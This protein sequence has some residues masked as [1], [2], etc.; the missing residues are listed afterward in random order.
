MADEAPTALEQIEVTA[1]RAPAPIEQVPSFI[2]IVSGNELRARGVRDLS[3]AVA[4]AAGVE[5]PAGGDTGPAGA[6]P[7]FWGLHEFDAFLLVVD[8][9]PWGGAFNP[10]IP[11]V[12]LN[13]VQRIEIVR[14]SA[15]V[16]Y[17]A[18]SFVG[19]IQVIHY[20][21]GTAADDAQIGYG[22]YGSVRASAS[23][24]LDPI[25]DYRQS[26]AV[27]VE[28]LAFKNAAQEIK[29]GH[30]AYRASKPLG[31]GLLRVD[32]DVAAGRQL[33]S[34]P[35]I[36]QGAVLTTL[37]PLDANS[38]PSD[39][40]ID[41][42]RY[43]LTLGFAEPGRWGQWETTIS[44]AYSDITDIRG[45]LRPTLIDD[46]SQNADS[47][48]QHRTIADDYFDTHWTVEFA[49]RLQFVYGADLLFGLGKQSSVNGAY[50]APLI[51]TG[52]LPST[53]GLHV[54]EIN[55]LSDRR[56]FGG[57]YLQVNWKPYDRWDI[58]GGVRMNQTREH[59]VSQH[60]DGF[61]AGNNLAADNT[62]SNNKLT[63]TVGASYRAWQQGAD[64]AVV[65]ASYRNAF[66]PAAID[67][68]PDYT[69][70]ILLPE[71]AQSWEAG[72]RGAL[73][74]G[75]LDYEAGLFLLDFK[76]LVVA[77]TDSLGNPVRQNAG[78]ERLKGAEFEARYRLSRDLSA[79][80]SAS[81]HDARFTDYTA[82]EGGIN[83]VANGNTLPMSP[84][85]LAGLGVMYMPAQG[86]N[87]SAVA[88]YVG[89]RYLDIAN[90][91]ATP[92]YTTLNLNIGYRW[93]RY[94]VS[95]EATNLTDRRPPVSAS[96]FGDQSYYLLPSRIVFLNFGAIL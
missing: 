91:A 53:V 92:A 87:A 74:G 2:T 76:N 72:M 20:P 84:H 79:A 70:D 4:L 66:K 46:G 45:F 42:N 50:Y 6:V 21:A 18:T 1:T 31:D 51:P 93:P 8:G 11:T 27:D 49:D 28:D 26:I 14:G 9:V 19:V 48:H 30:V 54:D 57:E 5:A 59:L 36:R 89:A 86:F 94:H 17:G 71:T 22:S 73:L 81:Y 29:N 69:P 13:N 67:F 80:V 88:N 44:F 75:R 16:M 61:D 65:F 62:G 83:V 33:P 32:A 90:M 77:T 7:S 3:G 78:G 34:S 96:E 41:E 23:K 10:A 39:A 47:Q 60:V 38:N 52:P 24:A 40:R 12:D 35:V 55:T 37:T 85:V 43:H 63:E 64:E 15:P 68:G 25:G 95:L 82:A 56:T 58:T